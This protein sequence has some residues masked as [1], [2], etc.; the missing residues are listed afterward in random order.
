MINR[1]GK[2][3]RMGFWKILHKCALESGI[4]SHISPHTIRHSFATHLLEA[5]AN[6]RIVQ[7]LLGHSS[8]DTTQIYT[9]IN[10]NY[11]IEEHKLY[12]PRG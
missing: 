12:H 2:L 9:N 10:V 5:G 11:L 3:T 6:L 1:G 8:L 7:T 4:K